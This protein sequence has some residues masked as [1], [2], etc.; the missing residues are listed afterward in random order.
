[1]VA[2]AM[3]AAAACSG[4]AAG[5]VTSEARSAG[6]GHPPAAP[7]PSGPTSTAIP[8]PRPAATTLVSPTTGPAPEPPTSVQP[9]PP[10]TADGL[11]ES[12][13]ASALRLHDLTAAF[14]RLDTDDTAAVRL[15]LTAILAELDQ[16]ARVAPIGLAADVATSTE[17]FTLLDAAL[18]DVGY[19]IEAADLTT[20]E[21]RAPA[22]SAANDRIRAHNAA[23]CGIDVGVTSADAP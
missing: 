4:D 8:D 10:T 11:T 20:L 15:S 6:T 18:A 23:E 14:R 12:W 22:I 9:E 19:D 7:S 16:I 13:C 17:A 3:L 5:P 1:M 2:A 21:A